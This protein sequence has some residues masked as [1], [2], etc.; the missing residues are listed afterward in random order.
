MVVGLN[1][2]PFYDEISN[3]IELKTRVW[4]KIKNETTPTTGQN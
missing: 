2:N 1:G 4:L 3:Q